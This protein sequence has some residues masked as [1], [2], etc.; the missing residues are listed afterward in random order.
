MAFLCS[1]TLQIRQDSGI[2]TLGEKTMEFSSQS[3][4]LRKYIKK[5]AFTSHMRFIFSLFEGQVC[6]LGFG[7]YSAT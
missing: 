2:F 6:I 5:E 3:G 1:P 7:L 4:F